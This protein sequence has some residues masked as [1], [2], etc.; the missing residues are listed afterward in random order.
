MMIF[1]DDDGDYYSLA[2]SVGP[3]SAGGDRKVSAPDRTPAP[4]GHWRRIA[5]SFF[6]RLVYCSS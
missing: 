5:D 6:F 3:Q 2:A 1:P 4:T